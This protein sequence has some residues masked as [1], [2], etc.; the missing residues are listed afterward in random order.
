VLAGPPSLDSCTR[1]IYAADTRFAL[2]AVLRMAL[3]IASAAAHLHARGIL[4]GDLYAHNI[5]RNDQGECLLGDFGAASFFD[6]KDSARA[7]ALQRIEARAFGCLLAEW[8]ARCDGAGTGHDAALQVMLAL[9]AR[10]L[11]ADPAARPLLAEIAHTLAD[12]SGTT[13]R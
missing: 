4:H 7:Q 9:Q 10:C 2:P 5:L 6:P 3:G 13:G 11:D 1:D 8:L 12:C